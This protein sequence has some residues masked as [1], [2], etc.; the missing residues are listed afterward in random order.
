VAQSACHCCEDVRGEWSRS[1]PCA[2]RQAKAPGT[3]GTAAVSGGRAEDARAYTPS[4][5]ELDELAAME[6][7]SSTPMRNID[8]VPD[9]LDD[10]YTPGQSR[11]GSRGPILRTNCTNT[12]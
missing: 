4:P 5:S 6:E 12:P 9:V 2:T 3:A 7:A 1:R 11:A 10:N 8:N